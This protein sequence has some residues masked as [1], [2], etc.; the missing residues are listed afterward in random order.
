[1]AA[2][3][4]YF[5]EQPAAERFRLVALSWL[6]EATAGEANDYWKEDYIEEKMASF[7]DLCWRKHRDELQ[8]LSTSFSSFKKLLKVLGS[9]QNPVALEILDQLAGDTQANA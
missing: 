9:R 3:F 5:L 7:L 2:R 6:E 8:A 1:M 4:L